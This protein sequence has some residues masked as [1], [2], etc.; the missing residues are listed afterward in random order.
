MSYAHW[1]VFAFIEQFPWVCLSCE[2]GAVLGQFW[3]WVGKLQST[4]LGNTLVLSRLHEVTAS[5]TV[6]EARLHL[7]SH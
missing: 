3:G 1:D 2:N 6:H 4:V 7:L 5:F